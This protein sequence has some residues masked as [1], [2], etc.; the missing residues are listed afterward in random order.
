MYNLA[1][2]TAALAA[3]AAP[4]LAQTVQGTPEGFAAGVTG[5]GNGQVVTPSNI[6]ELVSYLGSSDPLT[7]VIDGEM[8]FIGS[9]GS[10][11]ETGCAPWGTD[12]SCQTAINA[13]DWCGNYESGA[14]MVEVTYDVAGTSPIEV[15]SDKTILGVNGAVIRGK[16]IR[17]RE[18]VRN[19]IV[20]NIEI[21]E[22]NP[23]YVWGGDAIAFDGCSDIWID[24]VKVS[25]IGRMFVVAHYNANTGITISNSEF[26]GNTDWSASCDGYH[27][28]TFFLTGD[29]DQITMKNNYV[30]HTSG[31]SPKVDEGSFVHVV[32]NYWYENSGHC[33]EGAG[34]AILVEGNTFENVVAMEADLTS[35]VFAS[36]QD[37]DACSASIGRP[38]MGNAYVNSPDFEHSDTS[39]LSRFGGGEV[40][41]A[42]DASSATGAANSAGPTLS[43]SG[44]APQNLVAEE[45]QAETTVPDEEAPATEQ[46]FAFDA[47]TEE[48]ASTEDDFA[49]EAPTEET[50]PTEDDFAFEAPADEPTTA[51]PSAPLSTGT[52][53][54]AFALP[55]QDSQDSPYPAT[56][57]TEP[58]VP[59]APLTTAPAGG[60]SECG[61]E[62]VY[63]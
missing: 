11:T 16:G 53:E 40:A 37:S 30:H 51:A 14:G 43:G 48:T 50:A 57:E 42:V 5:G 44:G 35:A 60:N 27:Y 55:S 22:L 23:Q 21:T 62:Y 36:G 24:H 39:V 46:D 9:E 41:D 63:V 52:G 31:R 56:N 29:G 38:C 59:E 28:W 32:N 13:N 25:L 58:A 54:P 17:F 47:P 10:T 45:P 26:D 4:S 8:N 3:V 34:G 49:F 6:E 15:A 19:V 12:P 18:G 7:V 33:F 61:V 1:F 20:Q 2:L